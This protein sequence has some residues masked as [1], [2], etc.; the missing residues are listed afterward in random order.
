MNKNLYSEINFPIES[1][2]IVEEKMNIL[3]RRISNNDH[4]IKPHLAVKNE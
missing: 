4:V 1:K 3:K 2:K